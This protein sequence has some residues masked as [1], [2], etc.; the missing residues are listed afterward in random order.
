MSF[1]ADSRTAWLY[2]LFA[3]VVA[4]L[5]I[6]AVLLASDLRRMFEQQ[7]QILLSYDRI[8]TIDGM[9]A[10]LSTAE[11]EQLAY[12]ISGKYEPHVPAHDRA[13]EDAAAHQRSLQRL[14][15][16]DRDSLVALVD[17]MAAQSIQRTNET[18]RLYAQ[19]D[20]EEALALATADSMRPYVETMQAAAQELRSREQT[21]MDDARRTRAGSEDRVVATFAITT[22]VSLGLIALLYLFVARDLR[23]RVRTERTL[24]RNRD[25]LDNRV[26]A[27]T[28]ELLEA[29]A[30]LRQ[31]IEELGR[32]NREL[33]EFA[34]VASHDLQEPL[35]KLRVFSGLLLTQEAPNLS[36]DGR[37]YLSRLHEAAERMAALINDLLTYSRV[38]SRHEP[39]TTVDLTLTLR[40]VIDDLE[41]A[42]VASSA[43]VETDTLPVVEAD[44]AQMRQLFQ[45]LIGNAIKFR[46]PDVPC[47]IRVCAETVDLDGDLY[48]RI[49]VRDNGIGFEPRY[50]DR[51]FKPFQRLHAQTEYPG[52]GIG[53]AVCRR[54]AERHKAVLTAE[55]TPGEGTTF[56]LT[57]PAGAAPAD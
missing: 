39:F 21:R 38:R 24:R 6:D 43:H 44:S 40:E 28:K 5:L 57:L 23:Q 55:S 35:R 46:R 30:S 17:G 27:R 41:E 4:L 33:E 25:E 9:M 8:S 11:A 3:F 13:I 12:L 14:Y 31:S 45:Q 48:H 15:L 1:K 49:Y 52:T 54:I 32:S 53:L 37:H 2:P 47:A 18:I 42:L 20:E 10:E 19:R 22:I 34:Y 16:S 56:C 51:I 50:A 29:N 36:S 26:Q 7:H